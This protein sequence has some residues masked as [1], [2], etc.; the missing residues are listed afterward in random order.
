MIPHTF[1]FISLYTSKERKHTIFEIRGQCR[2]CGGL[3]MLVFFLIHVHFTS[4]GYLSIT[5]IGSS[6]YFAGESHL[7]HHRQAGQ[8]EPSPT[9]PHRAIT[10]SIRSLFFSWTTE[11]RCLKWTA[12]SDR[13]SV[14]SAYRWT[15][16][17][18]ERQVMASI[19]NPSINAQD[20][21][22]RTTS[23]WRGK[24]AACPCSDLDRP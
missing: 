21:V 24:E 4:P 16:W 15:V 22:K 11:N 5:R 12:M 10:Q 2:C 14:A 8:R 18:G 6:D 23:W 1:Y 3:S 17:S 7:L 20:E 9:G 19:H 13:R